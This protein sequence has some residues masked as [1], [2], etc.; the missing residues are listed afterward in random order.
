MEVTP[1]PDVPD[2][3]SILRTS[4]KTQYSYSERYEV[5]EINPP[6]KLE[7]V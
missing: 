6:Q 2:K 7:L 5:S 4:L 1:L 3:I